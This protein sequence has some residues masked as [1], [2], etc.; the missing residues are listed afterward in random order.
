M[1]GATSEEASDARDARFELIRFLFG[2]T[3]YKEMT[4]LSATKFLLKLV[5]DKYSNYYF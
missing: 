3:I 2:M 4:I 5:N 1:E